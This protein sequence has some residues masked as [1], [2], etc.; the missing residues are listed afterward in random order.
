MCTQQTGEVKEVSLL[1]MKGGAISERVGIE[2]E[3]VLKNIL[4]PN[5]KAKEKRTLTV[6]FEFLPNEDRDGVSMK[7]TVSAKL[8]SYL[9]VESTLNVGGSQEN[10]VASEWVKQI[11]GQVDL[12]GQETSQP[13]IIKLPKRAMRE[14]KEVGNYD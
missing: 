3:N 2:T 6:K 7:T 1:D 13:N 9:P 5:T 14:K 10:P 4:D 8:A 12:N 11:P